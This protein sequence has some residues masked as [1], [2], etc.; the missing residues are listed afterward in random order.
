MNRFQ[1]AMKAVAQLG[2][3]KIALYALYQI[4]LKSGFIKLLTPAK[5]SGVKEERL[6]AASEFPLSTPDVTALAQVSGKT[7][8]DLLDEAKTI[9][10]GRFYQF[11]DEEAI[12]IQLSPPSPISHWS[13]FNDNP[14][15]DEDIKFLWEPARFGWVFPLGRAYALQHDEAFAA[16]FWQQAETFRENNPPNLGPNWVS[17][18]E[19]ALRILAFTFALQV[20]AEAAS[21]TPKRRQR[22]L[23]SIAGHARRI[24]PTLLYA[25]AQNNNHLITEA[26]GLYTAGCILPN[27]PKAA[28]WRKLGWRWFNRA[29]LT[30]IAADGT[31]VQQSMNYHRLMLQA[32]LW[33]N[34][35]ARQRREPLPGSIQQRLAAAT[36]WLYAQI[37]T[38][39]G[40]VPNLGHNDGAHILPLASGAFSDY[41]P[42]VQAASCAFLGGP[43]LPPGPW[44]EAALWFGLNPA[45]DN[46]PRCVPSPG[47]LRIDDE[48]SWATLRAAHFH[49]R[50]AQADQLH[51]EL[52]WQG[53]NIACDP[54]TFRYTAPPPW[55]NGLAHTAVHN[56]VLIDGQDQMTRAG[57]FLWLD[58]SQAQVLSQSDETPSITAE[59]NGYDHLGVTHRRSLICIPS[60]GWLVRD[61]LLPVKNK[62]IQTPHEI[63]LHWLVP[64]L[65]W[66]LDLNCLTFE[67]D[68]G[69]VTL[70]ISASL[71]QK[72]EQAPL[73]ILQLVRAGEV[74]LGPPA[75][76]PTLGW[77]APTYASKK[78]A[79]SI[80]AHLNTTLPIQLVSKWRFSSNH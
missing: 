77:Y 45:A 27:H 38:V 69:Q 78:P 1:I 29:I 80:R 24:P 22:L 75:N 63:I 73:P 79:L 72:D 23:A 40:N 64:D 5:E 36:K 28:R 3:K 17:G 48:A 66:Q 20:F 30:Q 33:F 16:A 39:S 61:A 67:T 58:W 19:V 8:T 51:V 74:V 47:V 7:S 13:R 15:S 76:L 62:H 35:M 42:T 21:S 25:R 44:D 57:R 59:H 55:N 37:D 53:V 41:R 70:E 65:P 12:P 71:Q 26:V 11:G 10:G 43:L 9:A 50:P 6:Q 52:W 14:G 46:P 56:T 54:G 4:G 34:A 68:A 2:L 31:Y 32:A 18:Q 60:E 49:D